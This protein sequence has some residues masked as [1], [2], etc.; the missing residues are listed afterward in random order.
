VQFDV[1]KGLR[2]AIIPNLLLPGRIERPDFDFNSKEIIVSPQL[3][4]TTEM[5]SATKLF[6]D[7]NETAKS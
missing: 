2:T 3:K 6:F 4:L 7:A 5:H 1:A